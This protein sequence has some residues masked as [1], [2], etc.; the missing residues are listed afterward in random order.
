MTLA[1]YSKKFS[2]FISHLKFGS[3][4]KLDD[5]NNLHFVCSILNCRESEKYIVC[6]LYIAGLIYL[7]HGFSIGRYGAIVTAFRSFCLI[8][9]WSSDDEWIFALSNQN[10]NSLFLN[11]SFCLHSSQSF[12]RKLIIL[13][14]V[15]F[16]QIP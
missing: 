16:H 5:I 9:F 2:H 6:Y 7:S 11:N 14:D 12:L 4:N 8:K 1:G 13:S 3:S 10:T 15:I